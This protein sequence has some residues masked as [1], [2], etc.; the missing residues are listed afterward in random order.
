MPFIQHACLYVKL[1][2]LH[3]LFTF[4]I[5][6]SEQ[7]VCLRFLRIVYNRVHTHQRNI[8]V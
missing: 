1:H 2:A 6:I 8:F 3:D 7:L 5:I 4:A